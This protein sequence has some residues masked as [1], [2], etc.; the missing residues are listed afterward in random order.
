MNRK[1]GVHNL[2]GA[3]L[4]GDSGCKFNATPH[5]SE[6]VEWQNF[7]SII[8]HHLHSKVSA[9]V[10]LLP[11]FTASHRQLSGQ[12]NEHKECL[13]CRSSGIDLLLVSTKQFRPVQNNTPLPAFALISLKRHS[14]PLVTSR[15]Q[16]LA[17]FLNATI[18]YNQSIANRR[19][20]NVAVLVFTVS[21]SL[22]TMQLSFAYRLV[23]THPR[24]TAQMTNHFSSVKKRFVSGVPVTPQQWLHG[25]FNTIRQNG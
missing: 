17:M 16:Q 24:P 18:T 2:L 1:K 4:R 22:T 9:G 20:T 8:E 10:P 6:S 13:A 14:T 3:C 12:F 19:L 7:A 5:P 23:V 25:H 21:L 15:D 11:F